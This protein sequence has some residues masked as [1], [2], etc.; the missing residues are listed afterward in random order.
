MLPVLASITVS[1]STFLLSPCKLKQVK[2]W[3]KVHRIKMTDATVICGRYRPPPWPTILEVQ[4]WNGE[5]SHKER[6]LNHS[7]PLWATFSEMQSWQ[8]LAPVLICNKCAAQRL[9]DLVVVV[10]VLD[11]RGRLELHANALGAHTVAFTRQV[12]WEVTCNSSSFCSTFRGCFLQLLRDKS[13]SLC[14]HLNFPA[15]CS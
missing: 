3:A 10:G 6:W 14:Q 12:R 5:N 2:L 11:T 8:Q 7:I 15:I 1:C 4:R 9:W 13:V